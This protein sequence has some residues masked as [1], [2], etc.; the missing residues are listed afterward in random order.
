MIQQ[1]TMVELQSRPLLQQEEVK[2]EVQQVKPPSPKLIEPKKIEPMK[3]IEPVKKIVSNNYMDD[4]SEGSDS[5]SDSS[6]S[7]D[8]IFG[9]KK[10]VEAKKVVAAAVVK[11]EEKNKNIEVVKSRKITI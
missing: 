4:F 5:G 7:D 10:K 1:T 8:L 11:V 9:N 3:K 6:S 2:E